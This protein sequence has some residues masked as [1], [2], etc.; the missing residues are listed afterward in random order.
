MLGR[1]VYVIDQAQ[2]AASHVLHSIKAQP[3]KSRKI[4]TA[5]KSPRVPHLLTEHSKTC[6]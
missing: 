4:E 2:H 6:N 1:H 3:I 5:K